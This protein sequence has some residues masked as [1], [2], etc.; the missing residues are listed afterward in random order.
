MHAFYLQDKPVQ[1]EKSRGSD[2]L[3]ITTKTQPTNRD[4]ESEKEQPLNPEHPGLS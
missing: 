4:G 2:L 3:G 1:F